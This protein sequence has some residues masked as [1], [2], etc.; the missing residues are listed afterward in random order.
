MPLVAE[1][2][3]MI[4]LLRGINVG[5][6]NRLAMSDLR[7]IMDGLGF[8][9]VRTYIQSGNVV[10]VTP[11]A[12]TSMMA[13]QIEDAIAATSGVKP[14]VVVLTLGELESIIADN[15]LARRTDDPKQLHVVFYG[16]KA[17]FD[18]EPARYAPDEVA[19]EGRVAYMYLPGGIGRSKLAAALARADGGT[20]TTRNWRTI[21]KIR[22]LA[23]DS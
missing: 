4:G 16:G 8:D 1:R 6:K 20:G 5:G 3:V 15:P 14:A 21:D 13:R 10:F 11:S 22:G 18:L 9:D 7:R 19:F 23:R 12:D 17:G 2:N